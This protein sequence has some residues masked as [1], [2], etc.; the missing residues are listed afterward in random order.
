MEE[1]APKNVSSTIDS[2]NIIRTR[3]RRSV[4]QPVS[5]HTRQTPTAHEPRTYTQAVSR[6]DRDDWIEAIARELKALKDMDVWE[7]VELPEG[8]HALGTTWVFKRKTGP[9]GELIK[10]KARL[11]AQG[12]SKIEG[13]EYSDTF[14]PAGRLSSLRTCLAI[15][16]TE[17]LEAIQM[18]AVG[19]FLNGIPDETLYIK[20][21]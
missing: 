12:F 13:I 20:P 14:A 4:H 7:E 17:D 19:A 6:A 1:T 8:C 21:P 10:S 11:C 16:A 18:D 3:T 5:N 15:S 2:F 9:T